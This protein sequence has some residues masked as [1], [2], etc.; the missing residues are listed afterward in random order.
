VVLVGPL[1]GLEGI[2]FPVFLLVRGLHVGRHAAVSESPFDGRVR[3]SQA[4]IA[5]GSFNNLLTAFTFLI[6]GVAVA[7]IKLTAF[8]AHEGTFRPFLY[9][10]T[11][12]GYHILS[13]H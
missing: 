7:P 9:T 4:V 8:A 2:D 3:K 1:R 5:G 12:H 10:C 11:N 13:V 6:Y